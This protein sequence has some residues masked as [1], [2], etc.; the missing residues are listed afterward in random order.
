MHFSNSIRYCH[1]NGNNR[2][3][4]IFLWEVR[5][6]LR[7]CWALVCHISLQICRIYVCDVIHFFEYHLALRYCFLKFCWNFVHRMVRLGWIIARLKIFIQ[8]YIHMIL[9]QLEWWLSVIRTLLGSKCWNV[10]PRK[11]CGWPAINIQT[12]LLRLNFPS[13]PWASSTKIMRL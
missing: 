6:I 4:K 11:P 5:C 9:S 10:I 2:F 13:I 12:F 1:V 7:T 8:K 3:L